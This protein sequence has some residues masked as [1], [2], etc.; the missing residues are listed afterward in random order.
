MYSLLTKD[1]TKY[2]EDFK[3]SLVDEMPDQ[4]VAEVTQSDEETEDQDRRERN[5]NFTADSTFWG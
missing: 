4:P 2:R 3:G 5:R 1:E